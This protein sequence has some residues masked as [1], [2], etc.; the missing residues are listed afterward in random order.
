M[1]PAAAL[2]KQLE[3]YRRM[4]GEERLETALRLHEFACDLARE[5]IRRLY[6]NAEEG[7]IEELLKERIRAGLI[8]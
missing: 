2:E 5:G 1:T 4:S 3:L 7:R 8:G 6:P